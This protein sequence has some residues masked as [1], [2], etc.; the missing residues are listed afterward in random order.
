M[1]RFGGKLGF[2]DPVV[3]G[4]PSEYITEY[5]IN[6][7]TGATKVDPNA[8][9][10]TGTTL[11]LSSTVGIE[12]GTNGLWDSGRDGLGYFFEIEAVPAFDTLVSV[13]LIASWS[14]ILG[15]PPSTVTRMALGMSSAM[16]WT[17][18]GAMP[19]LQNA[20]AG[21]YRGFTGIIGGVPA[22]A[23]STI[24]GPVQRM[25]TT[26]T[27]EDYISN[28]IVRAVNDGLSSPGTAYG[29]SGSTGFSSAPA[30][31]IGVLGFGRTANGAA[32]WI[33]SGLT[34]RALVTRFAP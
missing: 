26:F 30:S 34:I 2:G 7:D 28:Q 31:L 1:P 19:G 10:Y 21:T 12:S 8:M 11:G 3:G 6:L 15:A 33:V 18:A 20:I 32:D 25:A 24:T 4:D 5:Q 13:Q 29:S 16:D 23:G 9:E 27:N 14:G 22:A 17:G